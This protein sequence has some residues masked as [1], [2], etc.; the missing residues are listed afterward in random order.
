MNKFFEIV[1]QFANLS[2]ESKQAFSTIL[3]K[4]ELPKGRTLIHANTICE[5]AYFIEQG[6]ARTY[7]YKNGKDV[8][9]WLAAENSFVVS[10]VSFLTQQP[11]RRIVELLE[12]SLLWAIPHKKLEELYN[13]YHEIERFGRLLVSHG[14]ILVQQRFDDLHFATAPERYKKLL[15]ENPTFIQRVPLSMIASYLGISQETLSRIRSKLSF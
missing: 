6:L 9:D 7:Y 15:Q 13:R 4:L 3:K 11:D 10:I 8:T 5:N 1:A 12:P 2:A 14:L